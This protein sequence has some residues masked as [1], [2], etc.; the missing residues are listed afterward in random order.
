MSASPSA[1]AND[2]RL[3]AAA[4]ALAIYDTVALPV[5]LAWAID[6]HKVERGWGMMEAVLGGTQFAAGAILSAVLG[7]SKD[8]KDRQWLPAALVWTGVTGLITL[9]G[10]IILATTK[11]DSPTT[12]TAA[13][14]G[15]YPGPQPAPNSF[16]MPL[17]SGFVSAPQ[18]PMFKM[19]SQGAGVSVA[20]IV[21][22]ARTTPLGIGFVGTF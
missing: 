3:V 20:P 13:S 5:D 21:G 4:V 15:T 9:H 6:G 8:S 2:G 17:G 10:G 14:G 18:Q 1:S 19:G 22:D 12:K 7:F 16:A 11:E